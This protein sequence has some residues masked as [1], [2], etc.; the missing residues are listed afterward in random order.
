M[1]RWR[2]AWKDAMIDKMNPEWKD[3]SDGW[4]DPRDLE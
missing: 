1:K 3:L 2:R 4:Y